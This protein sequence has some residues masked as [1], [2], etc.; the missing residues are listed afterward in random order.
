M[1]RVRKGIGFLQSVIEGIFFGLL[2]LMVGQSFITYF[3]GFNAQNLFIFLLVNIPVYFSLSYCYFGLIN[4][5]HTSIRIRLYA[6]ISEA[7]KG[8]PIERIQSIY[9]EAA[10]AKL[11]INRRL[12]SGDLIEKNGVLTIGKSRLVHVSSF[13]SCIRLIIFGRKYE[14]DRNQA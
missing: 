6:E 4:L 3:S 7:R 12:E 1:V 8:V 9:D 2:T 14:F 5:G 10:F 13:L 11:R